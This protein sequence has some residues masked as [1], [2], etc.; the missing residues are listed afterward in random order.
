MRKRDYVISEFA[1]I[2]ARTAIVQWLF[3]FGVGQ[4]SVQSAKLNGFALFGLFVLIHIISL[5]LLKKEVSMAIFVAMGIAL[6]VGMGFVASKL[7]I[8]EPFDSDVNI[9]IHIILCGSCIVDYGMGYNRKPNT[10]IVGR[11][12]LLVVLLTILLFLNHMAAVPGASTA[13][14]WG[15]AAL[16]ILLAVAS[17]SKVAGAKVAGRA[18]EIG[19]KA[20]V[21]VILAGICA[22]SA[23]VISKAQGLSRSF[24]QLILDWVNSVFYAC[25]KAVEFVIVCLYKFCLWLSRFGNAEE[26]IPLAA[27]GEKIELPMASGEEYEA[28]APLWFKILLGIIA[29]VIVFIIFKKLS[30]IKTRGI[31]NVVFSDNI[32]RESIFIEKLLLLFNNVKDKLAFAVFCFCKRNTVPGLLAYVEK[33]APLKKKRKKY[34]SGEKYLRRLAEEASDSDKTTLLELA[35]LCELHFY[36]NK[37]QGPDKNLC[38]AVKQLSL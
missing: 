8:L 9:T 13:L 2:F 36:S 28:Y 1:L 14:M 29:T 24:T 37:K 17:Y 35:N 12:D 22:L 5:L 21:A 7:F 38:L 18:G 19:G 10:L 16:A 25:A 33:K 3:V 27:E 11:F 32:K 34:E 20:V 23:F 31:P 15:L 6:T 30:K 26:E 4:S